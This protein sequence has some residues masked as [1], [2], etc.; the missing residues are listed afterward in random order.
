MKQSLIIFSPIAGGRQGLR[1]RAEGQAEEGSQAR[2]PRLQQLLRQTII[3]G[4]HNHLY[5]F[6]IYI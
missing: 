5:Q 4:S 3:R 6:L 2:Q 1:Y